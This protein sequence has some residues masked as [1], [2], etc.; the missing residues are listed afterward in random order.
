MV[1]APES[2]P[3]ATSLDNANRRTERLRLISNMISFGSVRYLLDTCVVVAALR[4]RQG[5]SNQ[6]LRFAFERRLPIVIH[7][8][9][10]SEYRSVLARAGHFA[11][12]GFTPARLDRFLAAIVTIAEEVNVR[13]LWRPNLPDE[14]DNFIYE[15]AF[16]ASPCTIVSHNVRDFASPELRWP[17]V[18]VKT[19]QLVLR[20]V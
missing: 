9:L 19:P 20:E 12:I 16:A 15:I 2:A 10:L 7:Y 6:V 17:G 3:P 13:Y 11:E 18:V 4:S 14:D 1:V 5:A 8:K